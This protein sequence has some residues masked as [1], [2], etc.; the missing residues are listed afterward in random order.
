LVALL[1]VELFYQEDKLVPKKVMP[2]DTELVV[3]MAQELV[4]QGDTLV[5][6]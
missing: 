3:P 6:Q 1:A 5:T 4:L 2:L